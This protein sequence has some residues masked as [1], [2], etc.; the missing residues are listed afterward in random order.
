MAGYL[1]DEALSNCNPVIRDTENVASNSSLVALSQYLPSFS[2]TRQ[3]SLRPYY[4]VWVLVVTSGLQS[5]GTGTLPICQGMGQK[6]LF[7]PWAFC[8]SR[9]IISE[10]RQWR[11]QHQRYLIIQSYSLD[12]NSTRTGNLT[13]GRVPSILV[14]CRKFSRC[15][16]VRHYTAEVY[17][18]LS[19]IYA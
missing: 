9:T 6:N 8:L 18:S 11:C 10:T 13:L 1:F 15:P 4:V 19:F 5:R 17:S 3:R 12:D 7:T 2:N 14:S 16:S